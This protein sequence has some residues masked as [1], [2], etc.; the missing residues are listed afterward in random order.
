M[1]QLGLKAGLALGLLRSPFRTALEISQE[2]D[3]PTSL[4][5][6]CVHIH[7]QSGVVRIFQDLCRY[8]TIETSDV[9]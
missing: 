3:S 1:V 4:G 6:L 5:S 9:L 2:G 7:C 8:E